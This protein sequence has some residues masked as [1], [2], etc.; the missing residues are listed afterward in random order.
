VEGRLDTDGLDAGMDAL[1]DIVIQPVQGSETADDSFSST[2]FRELC[3]GL[4]DGFSDTRKYAAFKHLL[5]ALLPER[6][7][8]APSLAYGLQ[9]PVARGPLA[10]TSVLFWLEVTSR[11]LAQRDLAASLFWSLG[12]SETQA[13]PSLYV[14]FDRVPA[15]GFT[16][17]LQSHEDVD[18]LYRIEA[19][20]RENAA[21]MALSIP[22]QYG[23]LIENGD[24][25]LNEFLTALS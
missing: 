1:D 5:D 20:G 19:V 10:E 12:A 6:G 8:G 25:A 2:T 16:A 24:L 7:K 17:L 15:S 14:Y 22:E 23:R 18:S 4:W 9:F 3:R 11:L 21:L 13:G